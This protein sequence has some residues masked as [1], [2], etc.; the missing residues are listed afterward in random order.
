MV[1]DADGANQ[2]NLTNY[3][4]LDEAPSGR[5]MERRSPLIPAGVCNAN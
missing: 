4:T 2:T 3:A 1:M 5:R